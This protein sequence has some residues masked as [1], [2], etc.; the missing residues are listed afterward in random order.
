MQTRFFRLGF[1]CGQAEKKERV[2][3]II[4]ELGL[5]ACAETI[6]GGDDVKGRCA[7]G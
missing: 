6:I 3:T 2:E 4:E 7:V 5:T 1:R